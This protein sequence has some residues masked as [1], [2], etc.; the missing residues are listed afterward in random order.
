VAARI[1]SFLLASIP[2]IA[3]GQQAPG[4]DA[5]ACTQFAGVWTGAF[6]Q[7]QYGPQR[8]DVRNVTP[9]CLA[10]VVHNPR[11]G[12]PE[13]VYEL[14]IRNGAMEFACSIPG[15][16]CRLELQGGELLFTFGD[17]TGF[18]NTGVFRRQP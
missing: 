14:P 18:V 2:C 5:P 3:L 7:G 15:G 6:S 17:P 9:Q 11:E 4:P 16:R 12:A 1:A 10:Q 8:I 13:T